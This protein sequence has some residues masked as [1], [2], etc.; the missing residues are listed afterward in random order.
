MGMISMT[1]TLSV[2]LAPKGITVNCLAP[3]IIVTDMLMETMNVSED[4]A[5]AILM[6]RFPLV[7]P[8][9]LKIALP[10]QYFL[11]HLQRAGLQGNSLTLP[12]GNPIRP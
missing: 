3:G 9:P 2:E 6:N 11:R 7:V 1:R 4:G 10:P 5:K 12:V 8:V